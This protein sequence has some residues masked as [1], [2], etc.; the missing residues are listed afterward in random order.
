VADCSEER[1]RLGAS[2][3]RLG[4]RNLKNAFARSGNL[5]ERVLEG[6]LCYQVYPTLT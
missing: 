1:N 3:K 5:L 2:A 4:S 6:A